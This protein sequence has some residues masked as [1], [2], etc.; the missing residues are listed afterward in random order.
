M[1]ERDRPAFGVG[2]WGSLDARR[3]LEEVQLAEQ[4]GYDAVWIGDSQLLWREA[5]VLLGAAAAL[6]R[7]VRLGISVTN[8]VTRHPTVT[9]SAALTLQEASSG[10]AVLGVGVGSTA[11]RTLGQQ[12]V[13]R[14]ALARWVGLLRALWSGE[15]VATDGGSWRLTFGGPGGG[16][17]IVVAGRGPKM[18][19]LAGQ[20]GDGAILTGCGRANAMARG[21]LDSVQAGRAAAADPAS[22]FR[23]YL[24]IAAAVHADR[25]KALEAVRPQVAVALLMPHWPLTGAAAEARERLRASYDY[26]QHMSR[27]AR[28]AEL[29]PDAIVPSFALAGTPEECRAQLRELAALGFDEITL[30]PYAAD[31]GTRADMVTALARDVVAHL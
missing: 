14:A 21:M 18:L 30:I 6:T 2:F 11:V 4:L 29:I 1:N 9:A 26:Y 3:L 5:Y 25:R 12:P 7:R 27:Q 17:P 19:R 13:S 31:D 15:P 16:P 10:R 23:T 22:S 20:I 24:S 8:P 28:Y